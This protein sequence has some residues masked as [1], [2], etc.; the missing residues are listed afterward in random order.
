MDILWMKIMWN[1][2]LKFLKYS[3]AEVIDNI[4]EFDNNC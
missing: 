3:N 1:N 4:N 2:C